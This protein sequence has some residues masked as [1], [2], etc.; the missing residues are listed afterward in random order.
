MRAIASRWVPVL[1]CMA[2]I[3]AL[4]AQS[5]LPHAPADLLD[6]IVKKLGHALGYAL[7]AVVLCRAL[8][9]KGPLKRSRVNIALALA[10]LYAVSDEVHQALVPGRTPSAVDVG[11][12][13]AGALA[14][15]W[16]AT[17]ERR[18]RSKQPGA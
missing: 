7:L 5:S 11:I 4:S 3:F 16:S 2:I 8:Q 17:W 9:P 15:A 10:L 6:I 13:F 18:R 12:D 1:L 14:G